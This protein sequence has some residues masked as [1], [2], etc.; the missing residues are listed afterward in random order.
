MS[1]QYK[2]PKSKSSRPIDF[3][4]IWFY[5]VRRFFTRIRTSLAFTLIAFALIPIM[6]IG[7]VAA[8]LEENEARERSKETLRV[9]AALKEN[10]VNSWIRDLDFSVS[11]EIVSD[12]EKRWLYFLLDLD[13]SSVLYSGF[14]NS[15]LAKFNNSITSQGIVQE[16]FLLDRQGN[17]I[18]STNKTQEGKSFA[19]SDFFQNALAGPY[20]QSPTTDP[21]L[22]FISI[23]SAHPVLSNQGEVL[24]VLAG[25]ANLDRLSEV[26]VEKTGMSESIEMYLVGPTGALLTPTNFP[27]YE[28]EKTLV[29][30]TGFQTALQSRTGGAAEYSNYRGVPVIGA[31]LW[32]PELQTVLLAEQSQREA[33]QTSRQATN[34]T[35]LTAIVGTILAIAAA[36]IISRNLTQPLTS[37]TQTAE[38]IAGGNLG[39]RAETNRQDEIGALA[40]AFNS[41]TAHLRNLIGNLESRITDRTRQ[42]QNRNEQ[43]MAAAEV[44]RSVTTILDA[45][46][47]M[48][49]V[50]DL[51]Q[52]RFD[53]YYVGLFLVDEKREWAVLN[54]GTGRAGQAMRRRG[55][56]LHI[57]EDSMIGWSIF[58]DQARIALEVGAEAVRL[59]DPVRLATSDLPDTRSEAAIP[60]RSRGQVLGAITIQ[61][62][63]PGAFDREMI[64]VFQTMA[65]QIAM[66]LDNAR[67]FSDAQQT[68]DAA[69]QAY[70]E[71]SHQAW[72]E[73][74]RD[75]P[76]AFRRD[77][78]G[79]TQLEK[80][81]PGDGGSAMM[82]PIKI[83]D[84]V[85]G[86]INAQKRQPSVV[87]TAENQVVACQPASDWKP[88]EVGLLEAVVDQLGVALDS[89]RLFE[90]TQQ[91]AERERIVG[92]VT[93]RIR[94]SLDVQTILQ[95]AVRELRDALNL[96]DVEIRIGSGKEGTESHSRDAAK[97][98]NDAG[99]W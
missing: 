50:V 33:Y 5:R 37:L 18:L 91:Q 60:L 73:K 59:K 68:I 41:M 95:T 49:R 7:V 34:L 82:I 15:Q 35:I 53:L 51:I 97:Q 25:R 56:R 55:H 71:L 3:L 24:G 92:E 20:L 4:R 27:E 9:A 48:Q 57:G 16:F 69:Q 36:I 26:M 85:I 47:L 14:Y 80:T 96:Q 89:A 29:R 13:P 61:S 46:Q 62:A 67:L 98:Q 2:N 90:Q 22:G 21:S 64:A 75:R 65:D 44:G 94:S 74:L 43:L 6:I 42:L 10:E 86:Y 58:H 93:S 11:D 28:T 40:V 77:K 79:V 72:L 32:L 63:R 12:A 70:A 45:R 23:I 8:R 38:K 1:Y 17:V 19:S 54:A 99:G 83:R 76:L 88:E 84:R 52:Q 30:S 31:Y 39:V 78:E 66:A 81:G 87:E